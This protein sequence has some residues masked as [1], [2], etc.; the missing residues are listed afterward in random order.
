MPCH[1]SSESCSCCVLECYAAHVHIVGLYAMFYYDMVCIL[2]LRMIHAALI[3]GV[4][5]V[6][7]MTLHHLTLCCASLEAEHRGRR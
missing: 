4:C 5:A 3:R 2:T 6:L 1:T 7:R